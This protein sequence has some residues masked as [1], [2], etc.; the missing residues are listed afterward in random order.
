MHIDEA[1]FPAANPNE[2][3]PSLMKKKRK[4]MQ[5]KDFMPKTPEND[6]RLQKK[7]EKMAKELQQ[8]KTTVDNDVPVLLFES[9]GS[10]GYSPTVK[11]CSGHHSAVEKRLQEMKEKRENLSPTCK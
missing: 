3:L 4:C 10:L 8:Q 1:L 11:I 2:H 7:F 5:P 9:N 6:K